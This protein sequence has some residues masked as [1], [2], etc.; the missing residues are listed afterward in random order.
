MSTDHLTTEQI[1]V[2]R[3]AARRALVGQ[4]ANA[5][6]TGP[7]DNLSIVEF[8]SDQTFAVDIDEQTL[9]VPVRYRADLLRLVEALAHGDYR[10][11]VNLAA[12][13]GNQASI[14]APTF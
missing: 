9:N 4:S 3:N 5:I 1:R 7:D 8:K 2:R 12:Y 14:N 11:A 10:A 6:A 13:I